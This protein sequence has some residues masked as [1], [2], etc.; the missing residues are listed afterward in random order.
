MDGIVSVF[1]VAENRLLREALAKIMKKKANVCVV[2]DSSYCLQAVEQIVSAGPDVL[3]LDSAMYLA[4]QE[5]L[6]EIRRLLSDLKLLMI[7]MDPDEQVFLQAI[8]AGAAGYVLKDASAADVISAIRAVA[9]G[10]G[11]CPPRLCRFLFDQVAQHLKGSATTRVRIQ[12]GLTRREQQLVPLIAQGLTNKEIAKQLN[13]SEQT[14][15]NHIHRII[16]KVGSHDRM[17]VGEWYQ[18]AVQ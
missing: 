15:K 18:R 17:S 7:G 8:R 12:E 16:Q 9:Q 2:G 11:I 10:E 3:V 13:L 14:I 4:D 1:L 6:R 5:F